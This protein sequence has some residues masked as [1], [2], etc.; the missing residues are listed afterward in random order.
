MIRQFTAKNARQ[1][2]FSARNS[3]LCI[4]VH[5]DS[6]PLN[7]LVRFRGILREDGCYFEAQAVKSP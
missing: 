3:S 5:N 4:C 2:V 7:A 1:L 6:F